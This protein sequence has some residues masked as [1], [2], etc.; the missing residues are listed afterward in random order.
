M[1]RPLLEVLEGRQLPSTLSAGSTINSATGSLRAADAIMVDTLTVTTNAD[2]GA[3]NFLT[4]NSPDGRLLAVS[5]DRVVRFWDV[6][7]GQ[8]T[9][10]A[11]KNRWKKTGLTFSPDGK[12]LFLVQD[13]A[14]MIYDVESGKLAGGPLMN[15]GT[16]VYAG[17]FSPD[18][19]LLATGGGN[20]TVR[21]W[22]VAALKPYRHD[23]ADVEKNQPLATLV[24]SPQA[25]VPAVAFSPD[26]K[27]VIS[28]CY[29][30]T[31]R[32]WDVATH[33]PIGTPFRDTERIEAVTFALQ[34]K[35]IVTGSRDGVVRIR[36]MPF[37]VSGSAERILLWVQ[38][39]TNMKLSDD[40]QAEALD[41]AT[42]LQ[43]RK[44]LE[45][46]GGPPLAD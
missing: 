14:G 20:G 13:T 6:A 24:H 32:L 39:L 30:G 45:E 44:L 5:V 19:K 2:S 3:G 1:F 36:E 7:R 37:P 4:S 21:L 38:V 12:L 11:I 27:T 17:A 26:G 22:N 33:K 31:S 34:G 23:F 28:G 46:F 8:D 40:G 43:R 10:K 18:G 42:W 16:W 9:N 15:D 41:G 35:L 25:P 29:D